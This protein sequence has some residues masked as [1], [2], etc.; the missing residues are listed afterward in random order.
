[1]EACIG[2]PGL[3]VGTATPSWAVR[4]ARPVG[5]GFRIAEELR[6]VP[7]GALQRVFGR[8][9][10]RR[11]WRQLRGGAADFTAG[12]VG[13]ISDAEIAFGM[14]GYLCDRAASTLRERQRLATG[15]TMTVLYADGESKV[16]SGR[17]AKPT[18]AA[19][20]IDAL[21]RQLLHELPSDGVQSVNLTF[22]S[23]EVEV[24][25]ERALAISMAAA[26]SHL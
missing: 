10:G 3:V 7:A 20:E 19:G 6:G 5:D 18:D 13:R 11:L 25:R 4:V 17:L 26:P 12:S 9:L 22:S 14:V 2:N 8:D 23:I 24:V 1:M 15:V 21:A 16:S